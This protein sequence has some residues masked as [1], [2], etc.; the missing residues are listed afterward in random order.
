MHRHKELASKRCV[1]TFAAMLVTLA[2]MLAC[3]LI[4]PVHAQAVEYNIGELG[5]VD[6]DSSKLTIVSGGQEKPFISGTTVDYGDEIDMQ[7]HWNVPNSVTVKSGD[8]F[9]YDLPE[10][11]T[12]QSGQQY[13]I[14]NGSGDVV[15]H[16]VIN[17]NRMVAAYTRGEDAGSNVTAYVTVKGTINSDKT[18]GN[19]G[20]DKTFS[21]PGYGD[22]TLYAEWTRTSHQWTIKFD[23]NGGVAPEGKEVTKLYADQKVYDGDPL[24]SPTVDQTNVPV[25]DGYEFQG[26]ST[27]RNDALAKSVLSFDENGKSLMPIDRDGTVYALWAKMGTVV[28]PPTSTSDST[29]QSQIGA[30]SNTETG[31]NGLAMFEAVVRQPGKF[32]NTDFGSITEESTPW[33]N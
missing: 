18:G 25:L 3:V 30:Y 29:T 6:K 20:G 33:V 10:N 9:V 22:V 17:G 14:I 16:Y 4:G 32:P 19:N 15:G 7:L 23:L 8:T 28:K 21:Y 12:F 2:T 27:V 26:W 13:D 1:K 24:I 31:L 11:L 5:W